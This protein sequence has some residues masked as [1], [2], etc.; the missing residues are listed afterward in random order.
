MKRST[1][2]PADQL[3]SLLGG[4]LDDLNYGILV[5]EASP[6]AAPGP[7][8][9]YVNSAVEKLTGYSREELIGQ[10]PRIL[11]GPETDRQVLS[12]IH[13]GL[14]QGKPIRRE[15]INY[16]KTGEQYWIELDI[17]PLENA[18]GQI[19]HFLSIQ[20]N[21][22]PRKKAEQKFRESTRMNNMLREALNEHCI[23]AMVNLQG[24]ITF[25]NEKFCQITGYAEQELLGKN[26]R[27]V[28]SGYHPKS[29]FSH[30]WKS[31]TTGKVWH[32]D[33]Q[34]KNKN[35]EFYW[36]S[37]T[38]F[39]L[40][41]RHGKPS[42]YLS[43]Q[44]DITQ[45]K[46]IEEQVRFQASLLDAAQ[47]AIFV[48]DANDTI[49]Y[50]NPAAEKIF[51]WSSDEACGKKSNQLLSTREQD[52]ELIQRGLKEHKGWSSELRYL[53]KTGQTVI[54]ESRWTLVQDNTGKPIA[55]L[56]VNSDIT[57]KKA[58]EDQFYRTQR[59]ESVGRL[60]GGMAHDLNNV[61]A[62]I[63]ITTANLK[64]EK[65]PD[66]RIQMLKLIESS[67]Q[68]A[69]SLIKQVLSFSKGTP[70]E[71]VHI[72]LPEII[73]ELTSIISETF[74]KNIVLKSELENSLWS[75][76]G[77]VTQVHQVLMNICVNARDAMEQGGE[78]SIGL[79]NVMLDEAYTALNWEATPGAYILI[80]ITD[81]GSGISQE[82][83]QTIFDPFFT[84]KE[85][86]KG[87]GIGLATSLSIVRS[88]KGFIN[89]YSELNKGTTFKVY[90]PAQ[91]AVEEQQKVQ[92]RDSKLPAGN[93]ETILIVDDETSIRSSASKMME[94]FGYQVL[95][96]KDG[97]AAAAL[98]AKNQDQIDL[99]LTDMSMPIMDGHALILA[100]RAMNPEVKIIASSG[101]ASNGAISKAIG[102]G[103]KHFLP[104][105]Y[106]AESLLRQLNEALKSEACSKESEQEEGR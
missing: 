24:N 43:I 104:K 85:H 96:A 78:I 56:S 18:Q 33:I 26:P 76:R 4:S 90:L 83:I 8:V 10:N 29:F 84:T 68:R 86:G 9:V 79:Q 44:T 6:L 80:S 36:V 89:V 28:N 37:A 34:N 15:I 95:E 88:H 77:D 103:V 27:L 14:K 25:A 3:L 7:K 57:E 16:S 41:N 69:T 40:I 71:M 12:E 72:N 45:R 62:P 58:L 75:I 60:A 51:G 101:L 13:R 64:F 49:T 17:N 46:K 106:T 38:V 91:A 48:T 92:V 31:I 21:I 39:P 73:Q 97:A 47:N 23:V 19:T 93:G 81:N 1:E 87:V 22:T 99:V 102:A 35:G 61:L 55:F 52:S 63:L 54:A 74:P 98:Y 5:T 30:L 20:R 59:I 32:D 42:N 94:R 100:L 70:N 11:Q 82:N 53:T 2:M 66:E 67:A 105:P 65:D 50:W